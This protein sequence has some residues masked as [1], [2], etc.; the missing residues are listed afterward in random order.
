[1]ISARPPKSRLPKRARL[2]GRLLDADLS[3]PAVHENPKGT[4]IRVCGVCGVVWF[5]D[6]WRKGQTC[7][8]CLG[9]YKRE[10]KRA[11]YA[12]DHKRRRDEKR[13]GTMRRLKKEQEEAA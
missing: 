8:S 3:M 6:P 11:W 10:W 7:A 4:P 9:D 13:R 2:G 5:A 12:A 1:V